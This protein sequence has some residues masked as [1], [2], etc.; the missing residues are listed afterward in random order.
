MNVNGIVEEERMNEFRFQYWY[1][2]GDLLLYLIFFFDIFNFELNIFIWLIRGE[3]FLKM[4]FMWMEFVARFIL[5][6]LC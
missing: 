3:K 6:C 1:F 5:G 2:V 4:D